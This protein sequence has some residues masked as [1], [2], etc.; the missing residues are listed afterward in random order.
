MADQRADEWLEEQ[1]QSENVAHNYREPP[2]E[3]G[4][5]F[6]AFA[7]RNEMSYKDYKHRGIKEIS[8][9]EIRRFDK[10]VKLQEEARRRGI[11][12][13]DMLKFVNKMEKEEHIRKVVPQDL[14]REL[15]KREK[16]ELIRKGLQ[17]VDTSFSMR[18]ATVAD[19]SLKGY[20]NMEIPQLPQVG[21][22]DSE[23]NV[24]EDHQ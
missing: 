16:S 21:R 15:K 18:T 14:L 6:N 23:I 22:L 10:K 20:S 9:S 2:V 1:R 19:S 24:V 13:E 12:Y 8:K 17:A 4:I 5:Y 11:R 7:N 3:F